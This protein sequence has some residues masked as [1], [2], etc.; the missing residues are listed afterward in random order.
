MQP[1]APINIC[2]EIMEN[3]GVFKH[4][5]Y[6]MTSILIVDNESTNLVF[7]KDENTFVQH[8]ESIADQII[9]FTAENNKMLKGHM[10]VLDLKTDKHII[11]YWQTPYLKTVKERI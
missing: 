3:T 7:K 4:L 5:N 2:N 11:D 10:P 1:F 9:E 8:L 6:E